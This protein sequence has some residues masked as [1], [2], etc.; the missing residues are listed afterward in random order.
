MKSFI[1][2]IFASFFL[3]ISIDLSAGGSSDNTQILSETSQKRKEILSKDNP[4]KR[5]R[6]TEKKRVTFQEGTRFPYPE[7]LRF[8]SRRGFSQEDIEAASEY[9]EET[10]EYTPLMIKR[11]TDSRGVKFIEIAPL[12]TDRIQQSKLRSLEF[13]LNS[14]LPDSEWEYGFAVIERAFGLSQEMSERHPLWNHKDRY[15]REVLMVMNALRFHFDF[16]SPEAKDIFREHL[17]ELQYSE[18]MEIKESGY[19]EFL[20]S[21][22]FFEEN[23]NS[24]G[25]QNQRPDLLSLED[26][27]LEKLIKKYELI[28]RDLKKLREAAENSPSIMKS[29]IALGIFGDEEKQ[30]SL[31]NSISRIY[32]NAE[33]LSVLIAKKEEVRHIRRFVIALKQSLFR[34]I[35]VADQEFANIYDA[36]ETTV[37]SSE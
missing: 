17:E 12:S 5:V 27:A 35:S 24:D 37:T 36:K 14:V 16:I 4:S 32:K 22:T 26:T 18:E 9:N 23:L 20:A 2:R 34:F 8:F 15:P 3:T 6:L 19:Y 29:I 7:Y 33:A 31:L 11:G 30:A 28:D 13:E 10:G 1:F 21:H 25:T